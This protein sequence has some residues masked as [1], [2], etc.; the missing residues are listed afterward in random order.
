MDATARLGPWFTHPRMVPKWLG[1]AVMMSLTVWA[2]GP[3]SWLALLLGAAWFFPNEYAIHRWVYHRVAVRQGVKGPARSHILHHLHPPQ[4]R[5]IFNDPRFSVTIGVVYFLVAWA[6]FDLGVA[7]AFS[8]GNYAALVYYEYVH[9]TAHR[10]VRPWMPWLRPL[11]RM[12]LWH[13]Y[14]SEQYWFGVTNRIFDHAFGSYRDPKQVEPSDT[15]RTLVPPE[16]LNEWLE[17]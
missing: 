2:W 16:T 14:K 9:F 10:P 7:S 17:T 6:I 11:K 15:V 4:L 1:A 5:F 3:W 12:H 8:A 13:H